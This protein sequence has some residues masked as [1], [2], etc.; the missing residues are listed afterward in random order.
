MRNSQKETPT[1][2]QEKISFPTDALRRYISLL[3]LKKALDL[4]IMKEALLTH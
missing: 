2:T 4:T 3:F 1:H